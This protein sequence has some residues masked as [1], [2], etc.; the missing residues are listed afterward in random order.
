ML[1]ARQKRFG[2]PPLRSSILARVA[3]SHDACHGRRRVSRQANRRVETVVSSKQSERK[4]S[5]GESRRLNQ[6]RRLLPS[7]PEIKAILA[8]LAF[9]PPVLRVFV[10]S[11]S[12]WRRVHQARAA[13][14]HYRARHAQMRNCS[15][16]SRG[17]ARRARTGLPVHERA[18]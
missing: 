12:L 3:S 11:C 15:T 18:S 9:P 14:A 4:E 10:F 7:A 16:S 17:R 6:M 13:E 8:R 1:R 2:S 5:E